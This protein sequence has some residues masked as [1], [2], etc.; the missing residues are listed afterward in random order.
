MFQRDA[1]VERTVSHLVGS[2]IPHFVKNTCEECLETARRDSDLPP[3][4]AN[5]FFCGMA[6]EKQD[7]K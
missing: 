5:A 4:N 1:N 3:Q 7:K 2:S 6:I